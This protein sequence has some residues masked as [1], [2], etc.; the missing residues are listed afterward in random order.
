MPSSGEDR[1]ELLRDLMHELAEA[2]TAVGAHLHACR[3]DLSIG[4]LMRSRERIERAITQADRASGAVV[5]LQPIALSGL[6]HHPPSAEH[7]QRIG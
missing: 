7:S 1:D 2:L 6:L 4:G 3:Q 5:R